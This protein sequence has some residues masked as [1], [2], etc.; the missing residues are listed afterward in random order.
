MNKILIA[1]D[2]ERSNVLE[3]LLHNIKYVRESRGNYYYYTFSKPTNNDES[4]DDLDVV[5]GYL[6]NIVGEEN[7]ALVILGEGVNKTSVY[8][9]IDKYQINITRSVD[10][11]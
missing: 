8:G 1:I 7:Y 9:D 5:V 4:L 2:M 3:G 11:L 6:F 10:I